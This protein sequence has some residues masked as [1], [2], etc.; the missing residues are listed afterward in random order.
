[1]IVTPE[2]M[3]SLDDQ[4]RDLR[5]NE[6]AEKQKKLAEKQ[7]KLAEKQKKEDDEKREQQEKLR[8]WEKHEDEIYLPLESFIAENINN[9][10]ESI[11]SI[12][13]NNNAVLELK[14][15]KISFRYYV[16]ERKEVKIL[17]WKTVEFEFKEKKGDMPAIKIQF[18]W[19]EWKREYSYG[20]KRIG[21]TVTSTKLFV[22]SGRSYCQE[23]EN[24]NIKYS[25][26]PSEQILFS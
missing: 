19:G 5:Q 10:F 26:R 12:Y 9:V 4:L 17:F 6:L 21:I 3:S 14:R 16:K 2:L 11:K 23:F 7:K 8:R 13:C 20:G 15:S 18:D 22:G 25:S 1:M 24:S